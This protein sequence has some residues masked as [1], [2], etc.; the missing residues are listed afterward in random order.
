MA[1]MAEEMQWRSLISMSPSDFGA[2]IVFLRVSLRGMILWSQSSHYHIANVHVLIDDTFTAEHLR[3]GVELIQIMPTLRTC[4]ESVVDPL[5]AL[6]SSAMLRLEVRRKNPKKTHNTHWQVQRFVESLFLKIFILGVLLILCHFLY[7][8]YEERK[9][10]VSSPLTQT[11]Q[12]DDM[13]DTDMLKLEF[14]QEKALLEAKHRA[15]LEEVNRAHRER[16]HAIGERL[17]TTHNINNRLYQHCQALEESIHQKTSDNGDQASLIRKLTREKAILSNSLDETKK[18]TSDIQSQVKSLQSTNEALEAKIGDVEQVNRGLTQNLNSSRE[19]HEED[20]KKAHSTE[21]GLKEELLKVLQSHKQATKSVSDLQ[22]ELYNKN[23][24]LQYVRETQKRN[25]APKENNDSMD[26]DLNQGREN[27]ALANENRTLI[28]RCKGLEKTLS[29]T[30][31]Q[32]EAHIRAQAQAHANALA[33]AAKQKLA[34]EK[35]RAQ[36]EGML[37]AKIEKLEAMVDDQKREIQKNK[38]GDLMKVHRSTRFKAKA[39]G[40]P[41]PALDRKTT[42]ADSPSQKVKELEEGINILEKELHLARD[43]NAK[44]QE[45]NEH[46]QTEKAILEVQLQCA[47]K[48]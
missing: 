34:D 26:M 7:V 29:E 48:D 31:T 30:Q 47:Q 4:K 39:S 25:D 17:R 5:I 21:E 41:A 15:I 19:R 37:K 16:Y 18:P 28:E 23:T 13:T 8:S 14:T 27:Q 9:V 22:R 3:E 44:I 35:I 12:S 43:R 32:A 11:P 33:E 40:K 24:E 42:E 6:I 36:T 2:P 38:G 10:T 45:E 1:Y 20:I 46:L